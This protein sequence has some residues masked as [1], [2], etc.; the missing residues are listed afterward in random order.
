MEGRTSPVRASQVPGT[1][2]Q[3][4][5]EEEA[6]EELLDSREKQQGQ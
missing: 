3:G 1:G 5:P 6:I 2:D 4:L